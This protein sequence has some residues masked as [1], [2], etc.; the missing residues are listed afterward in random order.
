MRSVAASYA[1]DRDAAF[2]AYASALQWSADR[3]RSVREQRWINLVHGHTVEYQ[4]TQADCGIRVRFVAIGSLD[5]RELAASLAGNP[6]RRWHA[7][8]STHP[9]QRGGIRT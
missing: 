3:L 4:V 7:R 9:G 8:V 5:G 1:A 2:P 6:G